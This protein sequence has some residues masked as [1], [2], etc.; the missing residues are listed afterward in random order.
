M[1]TEAN[2]YVSQQKTMQGPLSRSCGERWLGARRFEFADLEV[3]ASD[4]DGEL[5][6]STEADESEEASDSGSDAADEVDAFFCTL[7]RAGSA[8]GC[9]LRCVML[10]GSWFS[11]LPMIGITSSWT[12]IQIK[13]FTIAALSLARADVALGLPKVQTVAAGAA[14]CPRQR[15]CVAADFEAGLRACF[16]AWN[17]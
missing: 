16:A 10:R 11:C 17:F 12:T 4:E 8:I 3:Y 2:K 5:S 7:I 1:L 14:R 13:S 9:A 6:V 15:P